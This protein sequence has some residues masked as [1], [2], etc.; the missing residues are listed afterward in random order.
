[1]IIGKWQ[2]FRE[3]RRQ[4]QLRD[5]R[6]PMFEKNRFAKVLAYFMVVYYACLFIWMGVILP[7]VMDGNMA[8]FHVLDSGFFYLLIVDFWVRFVFQMSP[9]QEMKTYVLLPVRRK[10]ILDFYLIQSA[11]SWG[12][13]FILLSFLLPF[14]YLSV[15]Q[16]YGVWGTLGWLFG[17]W[18]LFLANSY[19]YQCCRTLI[20]QKMVW[21]LLPLL[22]HAA[23]VLLTVLP[24]T[25]VLGYFFTDWLELFIFWNPLAYLPIFCLI[26]VL[27]YL[28]RQ[29]AYRMTYHEV[30]KT[31]EKTLKHPSE[32]RLLNRLGILGEYLKLEIRMRLRNKVVRSHFLLGIGFML[33][34]SVL[35]T[36]T[37]AYD[38]TFMVS[39]ICLYN[40]VV[41]GGMTLS[42]VMSYEGNYIDG[43]MS[44]RESI[45]H[46]LR[47]KYL[48]NIALLLIP[49][50]LMIPTMVTGK[51][52]LLMN[53]GYLTF[54]G[55]VV[56]PLFFQYAVYNRDTLPMHNKLTAKTNNWVQQL[57]TLAAMF[58]P[59][60]V[61]KLIVLL[62][63]PVWGYV[64]LIVIGIVGI[65]SHKWWL[66]HIYQ[67][68]MKRRYYNMEG[69]RASRQ[70]S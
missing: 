6:H 57:V 21:L 40:Y 53:L 59:I 9:A 63:G 22:L 24:E 23:L 41:L 54:V 61:E 14:G 31:E 11:L 36:F 33:L 55:G 50:V 52:S 15:G 4:Q 43:L 34:F 58:V 51:T 68:F 25:N 1:M 13:V 5:R 30:A 69:F 38:G 37:E 16:F 64:V 17:Y 48:F 3:L 62:C 29:L 19:W 10:V 47:A 70:I 44:R 12:N 32:F 20:L 49:F 18:L 56:F 2:L 66:H 26:A 7:D 39:F 8:H 28:N 45:F 35:Q 67:R 46:L 27:Y 60:P 65:A 42:S